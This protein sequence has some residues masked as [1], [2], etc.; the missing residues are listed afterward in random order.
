MRKPQVIEDQEHE[1]VYDRVAAVDVAKASGMVCT[2]TPNPSRPGARRSTVWEVPATMNAVLALAARLAGDGIEMVTLESTA[3]YWPIWYYVLETAGLAV[4]LV[5]AS[6]ARNLP[7]RP[8]TDLDAMWL[9]R[10]TEMGMLRPSFVQPA[11]VRVLRDYARAR[12]HLVQD[13]TRCWQRLEKLLE[14][15][16]IKV[17]ALASKL[18]TVSAQDMIKA[19]IAGERDLRVLAALAR[20]RMKAKHDALVEALTSM[21]DE[22][23]R[24]LAQILLDQIA[25]CDTRVAALAARIEEHLDRIPAAWGVDADGGTGPG[26]GTGTDAAVLPPRSGSPRSPASALSWPAR[27]SPRPAWICPG[28]PPPPTWC[29]GPGSAPA[30]GS[31]APASA[32]ARKARATATCAATS[33]RPPPARPAPRSSSASGTGASPAAAGGPRPRSPSPAPSWSSSGTC[34]PTPQ[35][36]SPTSAPTTTPAAPTRTRR[37]ATTSGSSRPSAWKSPSPPP[38]DPDHLRPDPLAI[39]GPGPLPRAQPRSLFSGQSGRDPPE[40]V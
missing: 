7:G 11:P 28:S 22:H 23:H 5:T 24:E 9:A 21:F 17:S 15:A 8:K 35:P 1:R 12:T 25:F 4:Q 36:G 32:P 31:P 2:R 33:A 20:G 30:P 26:V 27:S 18:T 37:S 39:T 3:D 40:R 19:M 6:Q 16:L 14:G 34:S 29:P 13:R 38:P 10:L